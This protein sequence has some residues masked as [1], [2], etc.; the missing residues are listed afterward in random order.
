MLR[1]W[2]RHCVQLRG[3]CL[4]IGFLRQ[5]CRH[6][7]V[8]KLWL[9]VGRWPRHLNKERGSVGNRHIEVAVA[10][11]VRTVFGRSVSVDHTELCGE[12]WA[13]NRQW[14]VPMQPG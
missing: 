13:H 1:H 2:L 7:R 9:G 12:L 6:L 4:W 14:G 10:T 11:R 8:T 3:R 5:G